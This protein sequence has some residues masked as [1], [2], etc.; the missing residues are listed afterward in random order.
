MRLPGYR[1][2]DVARTH[3][4]AQLVDRDVAGVRTRRDNRGGALSVA[5]PRDAHHRV[6]ALVAGVGVHDIGTVGRQ[7]NVYVAV[8]CGR[9]QCAG[10]G[11]EV[12]LDVTVRG[13]RAERF[14][15]RDG[16]AGGHLA[17]HAVDLD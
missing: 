13:G 10:G 8:V 11:L 1:P 14:G 3:S 6:T 17:V 12:H 15:H 9:V 5:S 7:P 4:L 16:V 2:V